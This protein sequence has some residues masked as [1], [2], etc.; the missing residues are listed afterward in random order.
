MNRKADQHELCPC[1]VGSEELDHDKVT[2]TATTTSRTKTQQKRLI[3]Q[4]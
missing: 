4:E 2:V 1:P 3:Y